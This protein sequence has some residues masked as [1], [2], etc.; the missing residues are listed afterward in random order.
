MVYIYIHHTYIYT[1]IY[2]YTY[3]YTYGIGNF[4]P[5]HI[6][7]MPCKS[8]TVT[9]TTLFSLPMLVLFMYK[10]FSNFFLKI[11]GLLI[12]RNQNRNKFG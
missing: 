10:I 6:M 4:K 8:N 11:H 7:L 9:T 12:C 5:P 1:H 3:T 2:T